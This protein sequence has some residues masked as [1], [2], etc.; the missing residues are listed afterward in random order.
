MTV[1]THLQRVGHGPHL[2]WCVQP[3]YT[4]ER[5]LYWI[6]APGTM[7][8]LTLMVDVAEDSDFSNLVWASMWVRISVMFVSRTIPPMQISWSIF[9]TCGHTRRPTVTVGTWQVQMSLNRFEVSTC[10]LSTWKIRSSSHTFS[11]QRS[12]VSTNTYVE[13]ADCRCL[14]TTPNIY[15]TARKTISIS[16][17]SRTCIRSRMPSSLSE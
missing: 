5:C 12:S 8:I 17:P 13:D 9:C 1:K 16:P 3:G 10:T 2:L 11:K 4:T 14:P 15:R 6:A 7:T